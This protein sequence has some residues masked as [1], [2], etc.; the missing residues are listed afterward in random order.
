VKKVVLELLD[1]RKDRRPSNS[2]KTHLIHREKRLIILEQLKLLI[3]ETAAE[4]KQ[5]LVLIVLSRK[6]SYENHYLD[7][8]KTDYNFNKII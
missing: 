1:H 8:I 7:K 5:A 4:M 3:I 6:I 2:V